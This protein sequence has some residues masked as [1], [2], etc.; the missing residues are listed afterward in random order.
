MLKHFAHSTLLSCPHPQAFII[1]SSPLAI[2]AA[3]GLFG[4]VAYALDD[5]QGHRAPRGF[6]K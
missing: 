1:W 6:G 3:T 4:F 2:S 5:K